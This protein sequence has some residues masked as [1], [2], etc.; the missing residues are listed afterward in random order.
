[1]PLP[2][3]PTAFV[4]VLVPVLVAQDAP[5]FAAPVR[6]Q[7]GPKFLG[8]RRAYPS[9]TLHDVDGDGAL[10]VV[11]GDLPGRITY[12]LREKGDGVPRFG[13]E[14]KLLGADGKQLDFH[15]W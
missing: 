1:M 12:A 14:R 9:P 8:E 10:D 13:A 7:A 3:L 2:A 5:R 15:N 11:I 4:L 6:L